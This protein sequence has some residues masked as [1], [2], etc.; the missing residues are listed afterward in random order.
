MLRAKTF[1]DVR[2]RQDT[3][4]W[5]ETALAGEEALKAALQPIHVILALS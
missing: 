4:F 3:P 2:G 5:G 1:Q